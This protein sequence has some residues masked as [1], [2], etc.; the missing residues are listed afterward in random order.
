MRTHAP[1]DSAVAAVD[2]RLHASSSRSFVG[3]SMPALSWRLSSRRPGVRQI[4]YELETAR[5]ILFETQRESSGEVKQPSPIAA[6]WPSR[7]L[8]SREVRWARVR[9]C[10]DAGW[11]AWSSPLRV[12][13]ALL[14]GEDWQA[15]PVSPQDNVGRGDPRPV[16]LLRREFQ[17][18]EL[19]AQA[20]LYI[21][22]LGVHETWIN[23]VRVGDELLEPGWTAYQSRLLYDAHDVTGLLRPGANVIASAVGDGWWRGNLTW[24]SRRAI[25][26]DTTALM[27]QLELR[28]A[29]GSTRTISTDSAWKGGTGEVRSADLYDGCS[30][31]LRQ[32]APNWRNPRFNDDDWVP[33]QP[34]PLPHGVEL[35]TAPPVRVVKRIPLVPVRRGEDVLALDTGQNLAGYLRI[36]VHG[37]RGAH[38]SVRHAEVLDVDGSLFTAPL[39]AAKATDSYILGWDGAADLEP[40]FTFHG[41]RYA[42]IRLDPGVRVEA[43]EAHAISSDLDQTGEFSCSNE[44]VNKLFENV[45][46]SQLANFL[47][48]PTDCPQRDERLGWTGDIQAFAAAACANADA[49]TFLASWLKDLAL[50]QRADGYVPSTVPNVI[51]DH[52]FEFAGVAWGDAAT[53][54]PWQ[55]HKSYGDPGVL[56]SQFESMRA[57]VDYGVSRV[58]SDGVWAG[59]FHLGDWLDPGAPPDQPENGLTDRDYIASAYLAFSAGIVAKAARALGDNRVADAYDQLSESVAGATW[60]RWRDVA[61]TTQT[62]CALAISFGIAPAEQHAAIAEQ[63]A[64]LVERSG[65]RIGTGFVGTPLVLPALTQGGRPDAAYKLLLNENCPGWLYQVQR[66]ATTVWERW[67]AIDED[68]KIHTGELAVGNSMTSFNHYAYGAVVAWLYESV[69]GISPVEEEPGYR[70]IRFAPQPGGGL[71][72]AKASIRTPL[73]RSGIAWYVQDDGSLLIELEIAPGASGLLAPPPG[74][75]RPTRTS[76]ASGRHAVVLAPS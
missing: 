35:R 69:A 72:W 15:R 57:W 4:A 34:L 18:D 52:E 73:G 13:A 19:I 61:L 36:R 5:D 7:P 1:L 56:R 16:A 62:G 58:N 23:G 67:D 6:D 24:M 54:T 70:H 12:E 63:L 46:W 2:L 37:P 43:V 50:E 55:I 41:F 59:D 14:A 11:T 38:I 33:V 28:F 45:R 68:G 29:D 42:E 76:Y 71:A 21:T 8:N 39:R 64:L 66:G 9:V 53:F 26:G 20:R 44:A 32:I 17:L 31:D 30:I 74:W 48:L 10:T 3:D 22:A 49:R 51:Q 65:G 47:S 40:C 25:Y 60:R 27:A 75:L